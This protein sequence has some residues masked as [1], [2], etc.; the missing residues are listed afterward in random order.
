[1]K[2][3]TM[4]PRGTVSILNGQSPGVHPRSAMMRNY[5]PPK[6]SKITEAVVDGAIWYTVS[7]DP[8]VMM[9][10][11]SL[12]SPQWTYIPG[13]HWRLIVDV[14]EQLYSALVLRWS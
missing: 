13:G 5:V 1:M 7:I 2:I 4:K 14:H 12:N 6:Y 11:K 8:E 3:T 10:L 9:W